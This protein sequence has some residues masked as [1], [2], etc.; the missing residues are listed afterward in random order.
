[1]FPSVNRHRHYGLQNR[2][3][4]PIGGNKYLVRIVYFMT[5]ISDRTFTHFSRADMLIAYG[6]YELFPAGTDPY[7]G[8]PGFTSVIT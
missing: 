4:F 6:A 3:T 2:E 7:P 5:E 8:C 1:M